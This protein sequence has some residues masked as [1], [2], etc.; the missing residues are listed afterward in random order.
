MLHHPGL[1]C[2][3][4]LLKK[5]SELA[6]K[7]PVRTE[8]NTKISEWKAAFNKHC[9]CENNMLKPLSKPSKVNKRFIHINGQA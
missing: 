1:D 7:E 6:S 9:I 2:R 8:S 3:F 4:Q 5:R